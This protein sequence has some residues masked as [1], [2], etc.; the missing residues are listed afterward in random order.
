MPNA[1]QNDV[2]HALTDFRGAPGHGARVLGI[3]ERRFGQVE[4]ERP[5]ASFVDGH[6]GE[7]VLEADEDARHRCTE[8]AVQWSTAGRAALAEIDV[9]IG[10]SDVHL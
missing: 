1:P 4:T 6:I 3:E 5:E 2:D 7:D 8:D 10:T 9:Y